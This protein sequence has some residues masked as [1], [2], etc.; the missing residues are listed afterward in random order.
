[1]NKQVSAACDS[2]GLDHQE[3]FPIREVSRV[4][5]VNP[6]TLRAWERRYGLIQPTRTESGH[7][8][9]SQLDIDTIRSVLGWL[10]RGVAVSKVGSLLAR[11]QALAL[12]AWAAKSADDFA[13]WR[14]QVREAVQY[15][16]SARLGRLFE[17]VV[18]GKAQAAML[19]EVFMPVWYSLQAGNGGFGQVSEWGFLDQFLRGQVLMRLHQ[20]QGLRRRRVV[21]APLP[22]QTQELEL[23]I[24]GLALG[25]DQVGVVLMAPGQPLDELALVC[26]QLAPDAL[27]LF[28]NHQPSAE[29]VKRLGRLVLGLS[30]PLLLAGE[31]AELAQD[32]LAGSPVACLGADANQMP[33]RLE[34]YLAG[35]LDT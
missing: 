1:M 11:G 19:H 10:E 12:D 28:S 33:Q 14:A 29:L 7:R 34:Q 8:L 27:V 35:Q 2:A 22:E 13:R 26:E 31:A 25:S 9:Y 3:L 20:T 6:V 21:L 16:D 15:F 18:T 23:L 24:A 30:C 32:A 4:T 17:H 5:G